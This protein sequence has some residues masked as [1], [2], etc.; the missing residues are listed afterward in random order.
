MSEVVIA[1]IGQT[2]VGEFWD[3]SLRTLAVRAMRAALRDA[4]ALEP[5]SPLKPRALYIGNMLASTASH[6]SN[7]GALLVE[8]AGLDG[9]EGITVEAAGASG[10]AAFRLGYMAV[11]S[12]YVECALVLGVEKHTDLVGVKAESAVTQMLDY[13][14]ETVQGLTP[15]GQAALLM[16]RY[17][18]EY[19]PP[20]AAFGA[21]ALL[22]HANAVN[23]PN[24][25]YRRAIS[26]KMYDESEPICDPLNLFDIAPYADG[27]AAV[28]LARSDRV[29]HLA[30]PLVRV[31]GSALA[32]DRLALHD[33]KDLL[34]FEAAELSIQRAC[35]QA[36][37]IPSDVDLFELC[38]SYSIYAALS[39]EAAGLAPRGAG[40]KL[41]Q[42]GGLGLNG[43]MPICTRG[44]MKARGNPIGAAGVYQIVEAAQQ[45]RGSEGSGVAGAKKAL[46]QCLG[47]AA[48]TAAAHVLERWEG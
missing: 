14:Y 15:T 43:K 25:M 30:Q 20:R 10:G 41:A 17:L 27:A 36:G 39:L 37:I 28:L 33:R 24:A 8:S 44:G 26:Q 32:G 47:G 7:L 13:D 21:F 2:P 22:A 12:G 9:I 4:G 48:V 5:D 29:S 35:S 42:D 16:Q 45:L 46:V 34:A 11:A 18:Y 19:H 1:G 6:Q 31:T 38:D 40:W 23:N 3:V